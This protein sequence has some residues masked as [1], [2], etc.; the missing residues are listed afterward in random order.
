M[1]KQEAE[2]AAKEEQE[3]LKKQRELKVLNESRK[4]VIKKPEGSKRKVSFNSIV[5]VIPKNMKKGE[6]S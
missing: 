4:K 5:H 2:D 1:L 3:R 6:Y